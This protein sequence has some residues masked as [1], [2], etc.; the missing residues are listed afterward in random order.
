MALGITNHNETVRNV[1][2]LVSA[3]VPFFD[4]N[5]TVQ[6]TT[7]STFIWEACGELEKCFKISWVTNTSDNTVSIDITR[8]ANEIYYSNAQK[9]ILGDLVSMKFIERKIV[10][11]SG[12]I[13][14]N[15]STD[16][17]QGAFIPKFITTAKADESEV[18][19]AEAQVKNIPLLLQAKD[20]LRQIEDSLSRKLMNYGCIFD[21]NNSKL[22]DAALKQGYSPF[23]V[24]PYKIVID[25]SC[26]SCGS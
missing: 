7:V 17:T 11:L 25:S 15:G 8:I 4:Y 14:V 24:L 6:L 13:G 2:D 10:D 26:F 16:S 1:T 5:D 20:L 22:I 3:Q 21:I 23:G 9:S 12:K 18:D 19:F